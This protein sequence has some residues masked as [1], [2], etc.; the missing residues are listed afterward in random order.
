MKLKKKLRVK[1][2]PEFEQQ[3]KELRD[4]IKMKD[5]KFHRQLLTAIDREK[6]YLL[7]DAH[8]GIQIE[9]KKIPKEYI[10]K[11]GVKNLWKINLPGYWRMIY[12]ITG[13][14]LEIITIMLE[15]MNHSM[16]DKKFNYKKK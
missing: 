6:D 1:Y 10:E 16:Y 13:N 5:S 15:M 9:K 14:E 4:T 12:T 2:S 11:Y 3:L 7:I 8:R